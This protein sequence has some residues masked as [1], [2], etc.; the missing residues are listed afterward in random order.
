MLKSGK[1]ATTDS[2]ST[3]DEGKPKTI[4]EMCELKKGASKSHI[5]SYA[6][7]DIKERARI[8]SSLSVRSR[9]VETAAINSTQISKMDRAEKPSSRHS[10]PISKQKF[11]QY[12]PNNTITENLAK[13]E[14]RFKNLTLALKQ[15]K[16]RG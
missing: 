11:Q 4:K 5:A 10:S 12:F 15:V 1:L 9:Q 2:L 3:V 13:S 8:N 16:Y 7:Q 6:Q 14:E